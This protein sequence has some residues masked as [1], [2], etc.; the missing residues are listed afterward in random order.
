MW[1]TYTYI[2]NGILLSHK[3]DK[4]L[5]FAATWMDL[6]GIMLMKQVRQRQIP[7]DITYIIESEQY[8]KL[9]I[10]TKKSSRPTNTENK[11]M[12]TSGGREA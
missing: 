7:H 4:N 11:L 8:N 5:P 1:Y 2:H 6:E 9:L 10:I 12:V 3:K